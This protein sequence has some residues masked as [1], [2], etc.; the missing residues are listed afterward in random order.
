M[1]IHEKRNATALA[2]RVALCIAVLSAGGNAAT[3][4]GRIP[5]EFAT[6][7]TGAAAYVMPI[8][9]S[10]GL[11][12]LSPA[13][14]LS[15]NS[16]TGDGHAGLGWTLT[17]FPK[18]TRCPL[19]RAVDGRVQ[20]VR[21]GAQDRFCLDG[22]PLVLL[23]GA[24]GG[25]GAEYRL[26]IHGNERI[27]SRGR[28]GVGPLWFELRQSDGLVKRFGNDADSRVEAAGNGEVMAWALNEVEDRFQ[29]RVSY[30][31]TE[32]SAKGEHYPAEVRWTHSASEHPDQASL[33]PLGF[34]R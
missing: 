9:V 17:G 26:E 1:A 13:V 19:T 6:T 34:W 27:I 3:V 7:A 32:D 16:Q 22:Q 14:A 8:D 33:R 2:W 4:V 23:S 25:D 5:G 30:T 18:I 12:G 31:Y 24:Y 29:Q 10:P 20:G 28:Q 11:G 21:F 15:Y